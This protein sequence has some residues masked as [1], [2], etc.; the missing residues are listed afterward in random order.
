MLI[1]KESC[2]LPKWS[3]R[4]SF[5][6]TRLTTLQCDDNNRESVLMVTLNERNQ[7]ITIT[8]RPNSL[9]T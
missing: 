3:L 9:C 8:F 6:W 7:N 2:I 1:S 4:F 5:S